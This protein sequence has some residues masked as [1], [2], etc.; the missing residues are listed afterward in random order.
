MMVQE[1]NVTKVQK[2][3]VMVRDKMWQ[4]CLMKD[5]KDDGD[6]GDDGERQKCDDTSSQ[7]LKASGR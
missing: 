5:K 2:T 7:V 6:D 1:G 3:M 4:R